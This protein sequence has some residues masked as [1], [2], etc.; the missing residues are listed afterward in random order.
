MAAK[1]GEIWVFRIIKGSCQAVYSRFRYLFHLWAILLAL[2]LGYLKFL[3]IFSTGINS[4]DIR[5][6][7]D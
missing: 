2:R 1:F 3:A 6:G 7:E 5:K 4:L